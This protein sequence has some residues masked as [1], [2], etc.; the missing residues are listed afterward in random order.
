MGKPFERQGYHLVVWLVLGGLLVHAADGVEAE[1][2][3]LRASSWLALSWICAGLHQGWTAVFWRLA[4]H[5]SSA[6]VRERGF[7]PFRIGFVA[8]ASVRMLAL[9][10]I[11]LATPN[12][13]EVPRALSFG[14]VVVTTPPILWGLWSVFRW[15]GI[16][17]TF[18]ADHF[19][20]EYRGGQLEQRG[21]FKYVSN[22]MYAVILLAIYHPA[23][24]VHSRLGLVAAAA[25][26]AFVWTHY[27]C[28][29]RPDLREIYG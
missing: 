18:G 29:E 23:L 12:T 3:G 5:G 9:I 7:L 19:D 20:P 26:H 16:T 8:F 15:F 17:R 28:T 11:A 4:L 6:W 1:L 14:L 21:I 13:F 27:L 10:P 25:H 22:P 24:L 2:W